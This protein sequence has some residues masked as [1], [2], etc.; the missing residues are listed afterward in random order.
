M[1]QG[2]FLAGQLSDAS[3]AT[4]EKESADPQVLGAK[5]AAP[6]RQANLGVITGLVLGTPEFQHK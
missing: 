1:I 3:R 4:L 2:V 6:V 5:L